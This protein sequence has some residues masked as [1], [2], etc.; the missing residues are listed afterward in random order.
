[1]L[2]GRYFF[3]MLPLPQLLMI[4]AER[5][6]GFEHTSHRLQQPEQE[7]GRPEAELT[8]GC[9]FCAVRAPALLL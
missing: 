1:M 6:S 5:T 4:H 8:D 7:Q 3:N 9:L 2:A